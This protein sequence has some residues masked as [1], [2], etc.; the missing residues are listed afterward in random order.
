MYF[1]KLV[2]DGE[3][4]FATASEVEILEAQHVEIS[5]EEYEAFAGEPYRAEPEPEE[6][7]GMDLMAAAYLEGVRQ[8]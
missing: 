5:Q 2:K 1:Y 6:S 8:A 3:T 7:G 4:V